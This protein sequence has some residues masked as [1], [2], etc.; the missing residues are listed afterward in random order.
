MRRAG[1]STDVG[2]R[3]D[4]I[5]GMALIGLPIVAPSPTVSNQLI[6][7][8]LMIARSRIFHLGSVL[9]TAMTFSM[10]CHAARAYTPEEQQMCTGD[11]FRLCSSEIPDVDRVT[12][13]MIRQRSQLSPGC[14]ALFQEPAPALTPVATHRPLVIRPRKVAKAKGRRRSN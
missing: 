13:C 12:A 3:R 1:T 5:E 14:K 9:A 10:L 4:D 7:E 6:R 8:G 2:E 11:A